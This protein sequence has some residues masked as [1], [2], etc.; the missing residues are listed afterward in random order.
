MLRA[1]PT[2]RAA[3]KSQ[4]PACLLGFQKDDLGFSRISI[5]YQHSMNSDEQQRHNPQPEPGTPTPVTRVS[6]QPH[7]HPAPEGDGM[8]EA[9]AWLEVNKKRLAIALVLVIVVG[10]GI[11]VFNYM[12]EQKERN[13]SAALIALHPP[14]STNAPPIPA[15]AFLKVTEDYAGT[16]AAERAIILAAGAQ[17]SEGKYSDAQNTFDR[18]LK[19]KPSSRWAPDAAF[20]VAASLESQGKRDE[21]LTAYQ[22]VVTAY[23]NS[24]VLTEARLA[25]ARI[26]EAKNQPAEALKLYDE[27]TRG[28][29]MSMGSQDAMMRRSQLLKQ[30]PELDKP[31]TNAVSSMP[32]LSSTTNKPAPTTNAATSATNSTPAQNK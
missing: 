28:G 17:F 10:F 20:G 9:L 24:A 1:S 11:Y 8:I 6:A 16:A 4:L 5:G 32:M 3:Q 18:L 19:E 31:A 2:D 22:R 23:P 7:A 25:M 26:Y 13:A 21:A 27:L 14:L 12:A 30:H 15:S 29:V